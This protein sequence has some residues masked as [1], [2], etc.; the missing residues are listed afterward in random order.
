MARMG[1]GTGSPQKRKRRDY[2]AT[3][4]RIVCGLVNS[5]PHARHHHQE[6]KLSTRKENYLSCVDS[7]RRLRRWWRLE[8]MR[9]LKT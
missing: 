4:K 9:K 1:H 2:K 3:V 8:I 6:M 5:D 7:T